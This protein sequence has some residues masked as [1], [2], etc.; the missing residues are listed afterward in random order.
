M[1][2]IP[3]FFLLLFFQ[4]SFIH[5]QGQ[6]RI[7]KLP[8]FN[9]EI[10]NGMRSMPIDTSTST[11]AKISLDEELH[12]IVSENFENMMD[13]ARKGVMGE[14]DLAFKFT[15]NALFI[16]LK[17]T[18]DGYGESERKK[19]KYKSYQYYSQ[20]FKSKIYSGEIVL[21]QYRAMKIN[22]QYYDFTITGKEKS[23]KKNQKLIKAFW[24][25]FKEN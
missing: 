17:V 4:F 13:R 6:D 21:W 25:S 23:A 24:D 8:T 12:I 22:G 1:K 3:F 20:N 5:L 9:F 10:P 2:N 14:S 11:I 19:G 15:F 16:K 18:Y 7:V